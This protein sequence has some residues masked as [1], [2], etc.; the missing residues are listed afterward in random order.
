M[1]HIALNRT[2][3]NIVS[4][5]PMEFQMELGQGAN[6][7][8]RHFYPRPED[9]GAFVLPV[10]QSFVKDA[11][12]MPGT[13]CMLSLLV[14]WAGTGRA[15]ETTQRVIGKH[16]GRCAKQIK[17][18]LDDA[19]REGYLTY[20]YTKNRLGMI[21]GIKIFL[22]FDLLRP[23]L[24]KKPKN[25]RKPDRTFK[26]DT[27]TLLKDSYIKDEKLEVLLCRFGKSIEASST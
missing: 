10:K 14:G 15:I 3:R 11:R 18:Y 25:G 23:N 6:V 8:K 16:L 4:S 26:S 5:M 13:R 24:K 1:K 21:T 12:L 2:L 19:I 27:N 7:P 17:R 9:N 22:S 20:N